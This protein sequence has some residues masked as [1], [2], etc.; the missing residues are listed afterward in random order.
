M[1]NNPEGFHS[2]DSEMKPPLSAA[3][4]KRLAPIGQMY[5][6]STAEESKADGGT[7]IEEGLDDKMYMIKSSG[8]IIDVSK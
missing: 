7:F 4:K 6:A 3:S 1:D 8:T 2:K 5:E